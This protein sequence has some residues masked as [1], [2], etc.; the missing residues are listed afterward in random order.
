MRKCHVNILGLLQDYRFKELENETC[1]LYESGKIP[2]N[3]AIGL[4]GQRTIHDRRIQPRSAN[5]IPIT[6]K[7]S[8][9]RAKKDS[10][11]ITGKGSLSK[12]TDEPD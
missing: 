5:R 7:S 8:Q 6:G 1:R 9:R 3:I 2:L 11:R 10:R 4:I 12:G